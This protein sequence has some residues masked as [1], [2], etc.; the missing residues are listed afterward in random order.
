A[1]SATGN[2]YAKFRLFK[3]NLGVQVGA[4]TFWYS[5]FNSPTY[6]P[7]TRQWHNTNQRFEMTAPINPYIMAKVKSFFFGFE[8][9]HVQQGWANND[10]YSA[11]HFP[12]MPRS[13]RL[14]FRWD[15]SN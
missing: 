10:Y 8:M 15:L 13:V 6:T 12:L 2:V 14:N 3:K 11:P 1:T 7:Y 4:R 9:F 5:S